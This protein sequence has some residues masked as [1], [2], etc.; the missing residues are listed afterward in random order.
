MDINCPEFWQNRYSTNNIPW[1]TKT[2]T[3]AL[4]NSIKYL[5][6]RTAILGC[7][8]SKDSIFLA[9]EGYAIYPIDFASS[10]IEYLNDIKYKEN[11]DRL[12]PVQR[13]I[14]NLKGEYSDFFDSVIEYTCFCAIDPSKR[15]EYVQSVSSILKKGGNFVALFFPTKKRKKEIDGGPPF[16][17]NLK[18]TLSMFENNF[19]II[20]INDNPE[21]IKPRR[22]FET[23]VV[24]NKK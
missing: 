18:Q 22:G 19:N 3:P 12:F 1:D 17:V 16:Y 5:G 11:L 24:M 10:P 23:L 21:S 8:Y 14:F 2:T 13:D 9:N 7:G 15:L 6:E 4:I 20:K